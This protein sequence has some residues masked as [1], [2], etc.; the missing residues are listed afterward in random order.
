[1]PSLSS[2]QQANSQASNKTRIVAVMMGGTGGIGAATCRELVTSFKKPKLY[3]V[4]RNESAAS[5]LTQELEAINS[6]AEVHFIQS[7]LSLIRNVDD[8]CRSVAQKESAIDLLFLTAGILNPKGRNDTEEGLDKMYSLMY[9]SRIRAVA[10]LLPLL[11]N[12]AANGRPSRIISVLGAGNE[13]NIFKDDLPMRDNYSLKAC[14]RQAIAM[15][16][17]SLEHLARGNPDVLFLH[18]YPGPVRGTHIMQGFGQPLRGVIGVLML[19]AAPFNMS[20][21][22]CAARQL[23]LITT[24]AFKAKGDRSGSSLAVFRVGA[25]SEILP[26]SPLVAGYLK[27]GMMERVWA[28]TESMFM[29]ALGRDK[30]S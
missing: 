29:S 30:E 15:H 22:E 13:G 27:D 25:D 26:E 23:F 3:I 6:S 20:V 12:A 4:G 18:V 14:S 19:L 8:L 2:I 16:T 11:K 28:F 21:R 24:E 17:L 5:H 1:M 9:F 10:N 7:D